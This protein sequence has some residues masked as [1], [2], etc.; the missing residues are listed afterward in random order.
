MPKSSLSTPNAYKERET[1]KKSFLQQATVE[2]ELHFTFFSRV[3]QFF[4][5]D[6]EVMRTQLER[7]IINLTIQLMEYGGTTPIQ[8]YEVLVEEFP[9][10]CET[11]DRYEV[12]AMC[13]EIQKSEI[14]EQ[15]ERFQRMFQD[16]NVRYFDG[17]LLGYLIMV[18]Y[19]V[20]YWANEYV[21]DR[22]LEFYSSYTDRKRKVI[23][24]R[25]S[26]FLMEQLLHEMA[27]AATTGH[28]DAGW[29]AEIRRLAEMGAPVW[30]E[31]LKSRLSTDDLQPF[32][33][34]TSQQV[35]GDE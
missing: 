5:M 29:D 1:R 34:I 21:V 26:E 33:T 9:D 23:Y 7:E 13:K 31:H 14:P 25:T 20:N 8:T 10:L 11:F 6:G 4:T 27:H 3:N 19:D 12:V 28:Q 15:S 22:C 2:Y 30:S 35:F 16:F 17:Q 24:L 32:R 18:V